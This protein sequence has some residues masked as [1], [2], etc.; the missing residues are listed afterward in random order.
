M[1]EGNLKNFGHPYELIIDSNTILYK[2]S[3]KLS[4]DELNKLIAVAKATQ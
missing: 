2:L 4:K 3:A 1:S